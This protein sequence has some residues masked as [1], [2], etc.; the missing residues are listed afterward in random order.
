MA[1]IDASSQ[2]GWLLDE[3]AFAGRENLDAEHVAR[4]DGKEDAGAVEEIVYLRQFGLDEPCRRGSRRGHG[5][6]ALEVAPVCARVVAVDV[7]PVMLACSE[8][9]SPIAGSPT[10]TF[11]KPD[12]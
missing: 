3:L 4:Y 11:G 2:P 12:S 8:T 9:R 7:S 6:F 5:S 10:S 1:T